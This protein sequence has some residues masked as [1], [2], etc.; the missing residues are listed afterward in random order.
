MVFLRSL[1]QKMSNDF[2]FSVF[3]QVQLR[4]TDMLKLA[5][6][7]VCRVLSSDESLQ[8]ILRKGRDEPSVDIV[9]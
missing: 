1:E 5:E 8:K 2:L 9:S 3:I 7:C 4:F 6:T